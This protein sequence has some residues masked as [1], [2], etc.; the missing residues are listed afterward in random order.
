MRWWERRALHPKWLIASGTMSSSMVRKA[1][2]SH[3]LS[4]KVELCMCVLV[5]REGVIMYTVTA[6]CVVG[7]VLIVYM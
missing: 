4:P 6:V 5:K 7:G 2:S 1:P 3:T